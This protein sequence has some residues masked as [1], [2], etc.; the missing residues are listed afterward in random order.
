MYFSPT[1]IRQLVSKKGLIVIGQK[2]SH[3][4]TPRKAVTALR[5]WLSNRRDG[6]VVEHSPR[7]REI[8]TL[9]P[10]ST[11]L[12]R[13]NRLRQLHCQTLGKRCDCLA[14]SEMTIIKGVTC[15]KC[16]TWKIL[17]YSRPWVSSIGQNLQ[18]FTGN[19]DVS[20]W[21][22]FLSGTKNPKQT[23]KLTICTLHT[24]EMIVLNI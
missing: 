1:W 9:I 12:I 3:T 17:H 22:H 4:I 23:N 19:G 20:K 24:W 21:I 15:S 13:K 5:H 11:N 7:M 10:A 6:V 18:P 16:G 2:I 14:S 8:R